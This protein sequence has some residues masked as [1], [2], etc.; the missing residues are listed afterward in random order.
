MFIPYEKIDTNWQSRE[1]TQAHYRLMQKS[2]WVVTEKIHGANFCIILS[3]DAE[4]SYAKRKEVLL[5]EDPF[6]GYQTVVEPLELAF[7]EVQEWLQREGF[8]QPEDTILLHGELFG[9]G[10]PHPKVQP[11]TDVDLV[12]TG[13]YYSPSVEFC[14]FDI[15][16]Q[17]TGSTSKTYLDYKI[18]SAVCQKAGLLY[19]EA[20][21]I[22]TYEKAMEVT[23]RFES[24]IPAKLGLPGLPFA[25]LAEGVVIKPASDLWLSTENETFRPVLKRKIQEFSEEQFHQANKWNDFEPKGKVTQLLRQLLGFINENRLASAV[26]KIGKITASDA[27][28]IA[29]LKQYIQEDMEI[30]IQSSFGKAFGKLTQSEKDTIH[31]TLQAA[32]S[33]LVE[34]YV[35]EKV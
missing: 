1:L 35:G 19:T 22:G 10:Y 9:G 18:V 30:E 13:V 27:K 29:Q 14:V 20:L 5:P 24:T 8:A 15:A 33:K 16:V 28:K 34:E 6:F 26:S 3:H 7:L 12:Q 32:I 17:S 21:F 25:N 31:Q 2:E 4:I 23:I 11:N